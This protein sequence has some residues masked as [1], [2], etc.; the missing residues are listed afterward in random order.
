MMEVLGVE[1]DTVDTTILCALFVGLVYYVYTTY[2]R[3]PTENDFRSFAGVV[4]VAAG[5]VTPHSD[6]GFIQKMKNSV[7]TC[8]RVCVHA[9]RVEAWRSFTAHKRALLKNL[10][11]DWRRTQNDMVSRRSCSIQKS[12][13]WCVALLCSQMQMGTVGGSESHHRN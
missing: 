4:P 10:P 9:C 13:A 6:D 3:R 5:L 8:R 2:I 7:G 1:L 11:V 12:A